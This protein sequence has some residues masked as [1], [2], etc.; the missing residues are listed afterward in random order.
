MRASQYGHR[1]M[2][3]E[4]V[5]H[6]VGRLGRPTKSSN[7]QDV[8][9]VQ[10]LL[11]EMLEAGIANISDV[12]SQLLAPHSDDLRHNTR[13]VR[14]DDAGIQHTGRPFGHKIK[15]RYTKALHCYLS[16]FLNRVPRSY[17]PEEAEL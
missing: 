4:K 7:N 13:R 16:I 10:E 5:A 2:A 8:C 1:P 11:T 9:F 15:N 6:G 17:P 3:P 14:V 12:V